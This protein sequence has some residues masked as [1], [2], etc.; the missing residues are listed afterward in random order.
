MRRLKDRWMPVN[1]AAR[2]AQQAQIEKPPAEASG[3]S[4]DLKL[5]L[6]VSARDTSVRHFYTVVPNPW[7]LD[8]YGVT[9]RLI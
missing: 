2:R 4:L 3:F 9:L 5:A 8:S 1:R 7:S 6:S